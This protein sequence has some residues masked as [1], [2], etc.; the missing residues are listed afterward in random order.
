[1][2]GDQYLTYAGKQLDDSRA[3]ADYGIGQGCTLELSSRL[4]G[5]CYWCH[6]QGLGHNPGAPSHRSSICRD[7]T[8][9]WSTVTLQQTVNQRRQVSA[10]ML[11]PESGRLPKP[12]CKYGSACY[13]QCPRHR[14]KYDHSA[15]P[16]PVNGKEWTMYHGTS[17]A[18]AVQIKRGGVHGLQPSA[19]GRLGAGVYCSQELQYARFFAAGNGGGV[20]FELRVRPGKIKAIRTLPHPLQQKWHEAGYDSAWLV[21]GVIPCH[22]GENCVWD[23]KRVRIVGVAWSDCG[24]TW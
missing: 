1:V 24:F 17:Q 18:A 22:P 2:V 8:N 21:P 3:I 15:P 13:R 4:L 6:D 20:V 11:S 19:S 10:T 5:G 14:A 23:P 12:Q 9:P 16:I 7:P